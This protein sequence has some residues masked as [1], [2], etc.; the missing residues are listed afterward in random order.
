MTYMNCSA[1]IL[2][3]NRSLD[4][5]NSASSVWVSCSDSAA[6]ASISLLWALASSSSR[7]L[8]I[9]ER[10]KQIRHSCCAGKWG[11]S[12][13]G[14]IL[15]NL[16][17]PICNQTTLLHALATIVLCDTWLHNDM[18]C[19]VSKATVKEPCIW[20]ASSFWKWPSGETYQTITMILLIN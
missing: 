6:A 19:V 2:S 13:T 20:N 8:L 7:F 16:T 1:D 4:L 17:E 18:F 15:I 9:Q 12:Y 10:R 3:D 11:S 14:K 5:L